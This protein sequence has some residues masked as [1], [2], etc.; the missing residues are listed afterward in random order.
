MKTY[1]QYLA[2]LLEDGDSQF[3][4]RDLTL[5]F[6]ALLDGG[7]PDVELG[8]MLAVLRARG[9][10]PALLQ[11]VLAALAERVNRWPAV[12]DRVL[13]VSIGCYSATSECPDLTPLLA[14]LLARFGI[15][16]LL[17]GPLNVGGGVSVALLL[18]ELGV[19]PCASRQQVTRELQARRIA[20]VPDTLL[21]PGFASL[22]S[23]RARLGPIPLLVSAARLIDPFDRGALV[24][25]AGEDDV[26]IEGMRCA[27]AALGM[28]ALVL[29][30]TEG[31]AF[32]SPRMRPRMEHWRPGS[33][34]VLFDEVP[35]ASTHS[36][37][38]P[39]AADVRATAAWITQA[40]DGARAL[41]HPIVNQL[42][43]CLHA[44]GYC[45]DFNQAK[46]LAAIAAS[47]R[48]VA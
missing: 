11:G 21:A 16:V 12:H 20:F 13:P 39:P 44:T 28:R 37:A 23:Y 38:L 2:L 27:I 24:I 10:S 19:M 7:V 46:A 41:P 29:R 8:A 4:A 42:A 36:P 47:G 35:G 1:A 17:H 40:C 26:E 48:R 45:D 30:A 14:L 3:C 32:A 9:S 31:E 25:A 22:L 43:A 33:H 6:G 15:A 18:R 34:A 5:L